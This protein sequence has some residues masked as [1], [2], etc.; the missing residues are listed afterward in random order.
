MLE[1]GI[2]SLNNYSYFSLNTDCVM[3]L[4]LYHESNRDLKLANNT[5]DGSVTNS[6]LVKII[7]SI[8]NENDTRDQIEEYNKK[9]P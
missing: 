1:L 7:F 3:D 5:F 2:L 9:T 4:F 8:N 6:N